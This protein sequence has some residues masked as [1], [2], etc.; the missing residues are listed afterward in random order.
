MKHKKIN[1]YCVCSTALLVTVLLNGVTVSSNPNE[2]V[3]I[4]ATS[5]AAQTPTPAPTPSITPFPT[6]TPTPGLEP[7]PTPGPTTT[8]V[9]ECVDNDGDGYGENCA[10]GPDCK[11]TDPFYHDICPDCTVVVIPKALGWFLG[12]EQK[13]RMLLVI[14]KMGTIFDENTQVRWE[15]DAIGVVSK[16]VFLKRFML[17]QVSIDGAAI[18]GGEYRALIG[19]CLGKLT[20][21][22]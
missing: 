14:G 8:T 10:A 15:P 18:N 6:P 16:R 13:N 20:L 2:F 21:V 5:A 7:T 11:D 3:S 4:R 17:M 12:E 1:T 19:D 22:K 9:K